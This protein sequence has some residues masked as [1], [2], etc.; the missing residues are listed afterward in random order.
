MSVVNLTSDS[1]HPVSFVDE[2]IAVGA[3]KDIYLSTDKTYV[4]GFF[5]GPP[6]AVLKDRL[7]EITTRYRAN[8]FDAEGGAFWKDYFCWPTD[9]VQHR[10]RNGVVVPFYAPHFFFEFGSKNKAQFALAMHMV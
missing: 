9:T 4:V 10:G 7:R 3:M 1:G 6:D 8:L 2:V 5:R